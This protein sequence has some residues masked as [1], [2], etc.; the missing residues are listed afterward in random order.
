MRF[1]FRRFLAQAAVVA[2]VG[3]AVAACGSDPKAKP[4]PEV[5]VDSNT[6]SLTKFRDGPGRDI[7]DI[8]YQ[9]EIVGFKGECVVDNKEFEVTMDMDLAV[10]AGPAG[11]PGPVPVYYFVAVPQFFPK[12][13][14]K[15]IFQ[16]TYNVPGKATAP[17]RLHESNIRVKIPLLKDQTAA[18]YDIYLGLQL[19]PAQVE[20][21]RTKKPN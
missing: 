9:V 5:R 16:F 15:K 17:Q 3:A 13:E 7:S 12:P 11:K 4:C 20:Y 2:I 6:A 19:D 8:E 10:A 21:N 18:S 14:G 1:R